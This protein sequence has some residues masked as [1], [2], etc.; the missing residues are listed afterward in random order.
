VLDSQFSNLII[1]D[2]S[3]WDPRSINTSA[4]VTDKEWRVSTKNN[5]DVV[6]SLDLPGVLNDDVD[7]T[8]TKDHKIKVSAK[9]FDTGVQLSFV[10][11]IG[12]DYDVSTLKATLS[13]GVLTITSSAIES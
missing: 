13:F 8:V 9:R 3:S 2:I 6:F 1:C 4:S 7:V 5:G 10:N 11:Y 12:T